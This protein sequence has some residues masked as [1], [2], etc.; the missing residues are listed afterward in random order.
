MFRIWQTNMINC[1]ALE[2]TYV[3]IDEGRLL[4]VLPDGKHITQIGAMLR[5]DKKC[6]TF[7]IENTNYFC[8]GHPQVCTY[9]LESI[10]LSKLINYK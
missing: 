9:L 8:A 5:A 7:N 1:C 6:H 4:I 2:L 10:F 3:P